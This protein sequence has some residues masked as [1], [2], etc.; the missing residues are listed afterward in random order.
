MRKRIRIAE[1]TGEPVHVPRT[2]PPIEGNLPPIGERPA[3]KGCDRTL[4]PRIH[5]TYGKTATENYGVTSRTFTG[6]YEGYYGFHSLR[7]ALWFAERAW[8]AGYRTP[9]GNA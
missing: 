8:R 2:L 7:C 1:E 3:C 5:T 4:T 6:E 9:R